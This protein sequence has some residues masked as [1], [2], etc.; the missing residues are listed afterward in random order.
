M[1]LPDL[2]QRIRAFLEMAPEQRDATILYDFM[3]RMNAFIQQFRAI[4]T[5]LYLNGLDLEQIWQQLEEHIGEL[6]ISLDSEPPESVYD[7]G[8]GTDED[9][10]DGTGDGTE[11][12]DNTDKEKEEKDEDKVRPN[13]WRT[14][15]TRA[16]ER[17]LEAEYRAAEEAEEAEEST[18]ED[19]LDIP[20]ETQPVARPAVVSDFDRARQKLQ[21]TVEMIEREMLAEKSWDMI[22]EVTAQQRPRDALLEKVDKVDFDIR[23]RQRVRLT[24][25]LN[26]DVEHIITIRCR[27]GTFDDPTYRQGIQTDGKAD[28]AI[29]DRRSGND[30]ATD[31]SSVKQYEP[32][33][34][35][36][37]NTEPSISVLTNKEAI[38]K[39]EEECYRFYAELE[40]ELYSYTRFSA[41]LN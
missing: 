23:Q 26:K 11:S 5:P 17:A 35:S 27:D 38:K 31:I 9:R 10:S 19:S 8:D 13:M 1:L 37:V 2:D 7:A 29:S 21:H 33:E 3:E 34:M 15:L 6:D 40:Q 30:L 12:D 4:P 32:Q 16:E 28:V 24:E 36:T 20:T 25:E 39:H 18:D 41:T 14:N 22:G